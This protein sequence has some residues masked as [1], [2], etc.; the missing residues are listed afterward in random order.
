VY[1][2]AEISDCVITGNWGHIG[3]GVRLGAPTSN[4]LTGCTVA[5][6]LGTDG[7]GIES[8]GRLR[9]ERCIVWGNCAFSNGDEVYCDDADVQCSAINVA[10]VESSGEIAYDENC[11]FIDPLFCDSHPCGQTLQGDWSLDAASLCLPEHSPCGELIGA[12]GHGCGTTSV[13]ACCLEDGTCLLVSEHEC[14]NWN[15][16]Y[17]GDQ[18]PCNP[19]PCWSTPAESTTWGWIKSRFLETAR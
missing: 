9:L 6:N 5:A 13:G 2:S 3:G 10:G 18:T 8:A 14:A 11:F 1:G 4:L 15:G 12:L 17:Q 16:I 7:G 19:N